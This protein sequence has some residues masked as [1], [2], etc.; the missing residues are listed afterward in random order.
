MNPNDPA[1]IVSR[2]KY[3]ASINRHDGVADDVERALGLAPQ[4]A[5][6]HSLAARTYLL[7]G[8]PGRTLAL[9]KTA[10]ELGESRYFIATDPD[11]ASLREV[12]V[13]AAMLPKQQKE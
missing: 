8:D 5:S 12:E 13:F 11:L 4:S 6:I 7:L 2:A 9:L 1:M 10:I 3:Q